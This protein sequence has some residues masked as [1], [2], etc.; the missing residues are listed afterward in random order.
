MTPDEYVDRLGA[1]VAAGRDE[2]ALELAARF[3][4]GMRPHLSPQQID[5]VSGMMESAEMAVHVARAV[6]ARQDRHERPKERVVRS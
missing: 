6:Q 3:D 4:P 2:E 1:L 5:I